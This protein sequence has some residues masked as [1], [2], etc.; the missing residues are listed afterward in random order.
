MAEPRHREPR[1][2]DATA[3]GPA[4]WDELAVRSPR[5][6]ALQSH[7]WGEFKRRMGWTVVRYRIE[8]D[9][10]PVAVVSLQERRVAGRRLPMIPWRIAY[11]PT[12]P[13]L[14]EDG[15]V[16]AR[17]AL[18]GL[19]RLGVSRRVGLLIVDPEW[20]QGTDE[21]A[22]LAT[23]GYSASTRQIQV[24]RTGMLVPLERA[25]DEQRRRLNENTRR[26]INRAR[27]AGIEVVRYDA[28]SPPD[29]LAAALDEAYTMLVELG[30]RRG[31]NLRPRD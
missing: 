13:V 4:A 16:A 21:A 26:N 30:R 10:R 11:A 2:V 29:Q 7:A 5:G 14:L 17:A 12:G 23:A 8:L 25:E 20:E 31:F 6:A 27:K 22:M 1:L 24:A 9:E 18:E 15:P 3:D 19:A 28:A